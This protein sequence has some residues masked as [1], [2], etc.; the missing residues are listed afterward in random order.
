MTILHQ[1]NAIA[2]ALSPTAQQALL[3]YAQLLAAQETTQAAPETPESANSNG[4]GKAK[5][6][7]EV[8]T[9]KGHPYAYRRWREGKTLKSEYVGKVKS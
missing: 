1:I 7:V 6:W 2:Q 8:K 5:G 4:N 9:I 3:D